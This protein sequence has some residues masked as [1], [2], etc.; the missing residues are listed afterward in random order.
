MVV[1]VS[2]LSHLGLVHDR[3][4]KISPSKLQDTKDRITRLHNLQPYTMPAHRDHY[5]HE[6]L[7]SFLEH[8]TM[9]QMTSYIIQYEPVILASVRQAKN[10]T[11]QSTSLLHFPGFSRISHRH[12]PSHQ[13]TQLSTLTGD[14]THRKHKG[15]CIR[16]TSILEQLNQT[17]F[18]MTL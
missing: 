11:P 7:H 15:Q 6:N 18:I 14:P 5:F 13:M 2:F 3:S 4:S 17:N 1:A 16:Q 12:P 10:I 8:A 9:Q